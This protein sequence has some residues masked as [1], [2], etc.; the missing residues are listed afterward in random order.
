[1]RA[2]QDEQV[3]ALFNGERIA[4]GCRGRRDSP[5]ITNKVG[6]R[7]AIAFAVVLVGFATAATAISLRN[8][9]PA[10]HSINAGANL[11]GGVAGSGGVEPALY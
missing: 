6:C 10:E 2:T 3:T 1:M 4:P 7:I 11:A 8:S 9:K 5:Q